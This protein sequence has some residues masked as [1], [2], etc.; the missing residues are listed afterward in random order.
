MG[1]FASLA[2]GLDDIFAG[3]VVARA[4]FMSAVARRMVGEMLR[5][6]R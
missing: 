6:R 4:A 5:G 2:F 3:T 1:V